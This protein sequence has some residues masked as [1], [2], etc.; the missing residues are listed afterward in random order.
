MSTSG[1]REGTSVVYHH[2]Y[3]CLF[4][5]SG[6]CCA[7]P[8]TGYEEIVG[9]SKSPLGPFVDQLGVPLM[10]GGGTVVLATNGNGFVGPEAGLFSKQVLAG[11]G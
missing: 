2:G 11:T 9:R 7:R 10:Q 5:A 8:N 6:N 1:R 3:Y 4:A